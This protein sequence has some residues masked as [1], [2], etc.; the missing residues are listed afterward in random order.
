MRF[1]KNPK[2][3]WPIELKS[4]VN[5]DAEEGQ[6]KKLANLIDSYKGR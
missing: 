3:L 5:P 4:G 6:E 1:E 2:Y